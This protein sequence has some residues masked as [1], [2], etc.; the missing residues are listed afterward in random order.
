[1]PG[2]QKKTIDVNHCYSLYLGNIFK[3]LDFCPS[4]YERESKDVSV[5]KMK[6]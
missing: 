3:N 2:K 5:K 6:K 1:M 4:Q